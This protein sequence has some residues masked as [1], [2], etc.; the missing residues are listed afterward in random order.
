MYVSVR[1]SPSS[2]M[3]CAGDSSFRVVLK[4]TPAFFSSAM[5]NFGFS[6]FDAYSFINESELTGIVVVTHAG[7]MKKS[8]IMHNLLQRNYQMG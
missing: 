7:I 2:S 3:I 1:L 4:F 8:L 5:V 6:P